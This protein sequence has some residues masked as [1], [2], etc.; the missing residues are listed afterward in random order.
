MLNMPDTYK[1][2]VI[3]D[4]GI[5]G[6]PITIKLLTTL[7]ITAEELAYLVETGILVN[8]DSIIEYKLNS[9]PTLFCENKDLEHANQYHYIKKLI[10]E[11]NYQ[12]LVSY[13]L[14]RHQI[15]KLN[16]FEAYVYK[17][18]STIAKIK[19]INKVPKTS[20]TKPTNLKEAI[21]G[22]HFGLA[23]SFVNESKKELSNPEEK[24]IITI[25]LNE[26]VEL[27][28]SIIKDNENRKKQE[29]LEREKYFLLSQIESMRHT[30]ETMIILKNIDNKRKRK[31][32]QVAKSIPELD[33]FSIG[34]KGENLVIRLIN[35]YIENKHPKRCAKEAL[36]AYINKD[37][38]L[39][40]SLY[41]KIM[42]TEKF[43]T[44]ETCGMLGLTYYHLNNIPEA[45]KYMT[46][47]FELD[48]GYKTNKIDFKTLIK[49]LKA[50]SDDT[51]ESKVTNLVNKH[52][53]QLV[54]YDFTE[55]ET[56]ANDLKTGNI[57]LEIATQKLG[58][59]LEQTQLIR[60]I[61]AR[62]CF[63]EGLYSE[64]DKLVQAVAEEK[65]ASLAVV[66]LITD[67]RRKRNIYYYEQKHAK[68]V[69]AE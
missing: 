37:Y 22:N 59:T 9:I 13:L 34:R 16:Y 32:I 40:L 30:Q 10:N 64:G 58:L 57:S 35:P 41:T 63:T 52:D 36:N 1:L 50:P 56:L 47:S 7:G 26:I 60:L 14:K 29:E 66:F 27:I 12:E 28:T 62:D 61:Y 19:E 67:I 65:S 54:E 48:R 24:Q 18:S 33:V 3:Y 44:A 2:Q 11:Q 51:T 55:I 53:A 4:V 69:L 5:K 20:E 45:I 21:V 68:K 46:L 38:Q 23:M 25:L 8:I 17:I 39:A 42:L 31:L 49:Y 43:I 6:L 15:R